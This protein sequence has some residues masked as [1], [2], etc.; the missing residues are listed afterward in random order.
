VKGYVRKKKKNSGR[1]E[2]SNRLALYVVTDCGEICNRSIMKQMNRWDDLRRNTEEDHE[3][4]NNRDGLGFGYA[5]PWC[6]K[7]S[8]KAS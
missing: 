4:A 2:L 5:T 6:D 1:G 7:V 3:K 8:V